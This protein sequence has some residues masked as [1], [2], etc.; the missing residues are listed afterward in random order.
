MEIKSTFDR[1]KER[2]TARLVTL[3]VEKDGKGKEI[4]AQKAS[5]E[6]IRAKRKSALLLEAGWEIGSSDRAGRTEDQGAGEGSL[7]P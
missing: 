5:L 4:E 3:K 1:E 7:V 6:E 2:I